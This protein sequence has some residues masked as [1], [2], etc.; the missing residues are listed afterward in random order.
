M[1]DCGVSLRGFERE[2][3]DLGAG[4]KEGG[5]HSRLATVRK[6]RQFYREGRLE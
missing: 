3:I 6:Q 5:V 1:G 4:S 2:L